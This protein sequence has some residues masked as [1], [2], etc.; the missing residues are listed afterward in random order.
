M[1]AASNCTPSQ[2]H[3]LT[4]GST[5]IVPLQANGVLS[6]LQIAVSGHGYDANRQ[7]QQFIAAL[8]ALVPKPPSFFTLTYCMEMVRNRTFHSAFERLAYLHSLVEAPQ[9][10]TKKPFSKV[11]AQVDMISEV[12]FLAPGLGVHAVVTSKSQ[13]SSVLYLCYN[14]DGSIPISKEQHVRVVPFRELADYSVRSLRLALVEKYKLC[15]YC[16]GHMNAKC[17]GGSGCWSVIK[18]EALNAF[19]KTL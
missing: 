4:I 13:Q 7:L 3:S 14:P 17:F 1:Q 10:Q 16:L 6:S 18:A 8:F 19:A 2:I 15:L 12:P 9:K 11:L 5:T